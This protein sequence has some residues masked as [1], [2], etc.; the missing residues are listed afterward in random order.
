MNLDRLSSLGVLSDRPKLDANLRVI[1]LL[2]SLMGILASEGA[3]FFGYLEY[4]L[5]IYLVTLLVCLPGF[6]VSD[7]ISK[8]LRAL[9]LVPVFRFVNVGMPVVVQQTVLWLP[10][11]YGPLIPGLYLFGRYHP[12]I[13]L[14]VFGQPKRFVLL[15]PISLALALLF[16]NVEYSFLQPEAM[17]PLWNPQNL[18]VLS[19]VMLL[20]VSLAEELLFRGILQQS[21]E[22]S[23]GTIP[24]LLLA[25]IL[26][27]VVHSGYALLPEIGYAVGIG[28]ILGL[29]YDWTESLALVTIVHGTANV[30]LFALIP[31]QGPIF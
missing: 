9:A 23:L 20:F 2:L 11:V 18:F 21:F 5:W 24:G 22:E 4:A 28:L 16:A 19:V 13:T 6:F 29:L 26:F 25:S 7:E 30:V 15:L 14:S 3:I 31:F 1:A 8:M 27:G 12:S 17:I 10:L